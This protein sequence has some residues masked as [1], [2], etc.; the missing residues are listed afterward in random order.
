MAAPNHT[1]ISVPANPR[2]KRV[3]RRLGGERGQEHRSCDRRLRVGVRKPGPEG[4]HRRVEQEG[5]EDQR[6]RCTPGIRRHVPEGERPGLGPVEHDPSEQAQ[7]AE[8]MD[9]KVA[10]AGGDSGRF[11]AQPDEERRRNRHQLPEHEKREE[12]AAN[13]TPSAAPA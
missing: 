4:R 8:D 13:V 7:A 9:Q 1:R 2:I 3:D 12:V 11:A 10:E 6:E 5:D